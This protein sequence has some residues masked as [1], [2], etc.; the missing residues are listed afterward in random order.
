M[1]PCHKYVHVAVVSSSMNLS[2][3]PVIKFD[4]VFDFSQCIVLFCFHMQL[5]IHMHKFKK[6]E[7]LVF[8]AS[9]CLLQILYIPLLTSKDAIQYLFEF[10]VG[11]KKSQRK[12]TLKSSL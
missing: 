12:T 8:W 2:E 6:K 1:R 3:E 11:I 5:P 9:K 7:L 10:Y 4:S